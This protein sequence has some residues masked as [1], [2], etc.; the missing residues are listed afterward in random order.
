MKKPQA[1][2]HTQE[3]LVILKKFGTIAVNK[4]VKGYKVG[5]MWYVY[6]FDDW[7]Y[8]PESDVEN[9]KLIRWRYNR[10]E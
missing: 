1:N 7:H 8:V 6:I 9:V 10:N 5:K 3:K 4:V 2:P